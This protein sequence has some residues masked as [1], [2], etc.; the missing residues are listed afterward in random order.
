MGQWTG[1]WT[2]LRSPPDTPPGPTALNLPFRIEAFD[3]LPSTQDEMRARLE[4]GENVHGLV[5]RAA[6]QEAARGRRAR[7]WSS[8]LGGSYQ[9]LAV[10][11][12]APPPSR[13][14]VSVAL[15]VGLA[16]T[17]PTYGAR[18]SI[19]WPNDLLYKGRKLGGILAE[20]ARG[21]LLVG[22]GVNVNN[23][24]PKDF[25]SL[26]GWDVE[27]VHMV[28]LEGLACGLALEPH[29]LPQRFAPFD[30]LAGQKVSFSSSGR[31]GE[32]VTEGVAAGVTPEG[33]LKVT[34]ADGVRLL[35]G[36]RLVHYTLKS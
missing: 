8:A 29:T 15:A 27:G 18:V 24:V 7:D 33:L 34:C 2:A 30:L 5:I 35:G 32:S 31:A 13:G 12:G 22:V 26:R 36:E 16:E 3:T 19:K 23:S 28:V 21:H 20:H 14:V 1:R 4:R 9:T 25:A 6:V 11:S 17:F 10:R